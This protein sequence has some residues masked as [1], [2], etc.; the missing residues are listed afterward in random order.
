MTDVLPKEV[1]YFGKKENVWI[2]IPKYVPNLVATLRVIFRG[3]GANKTRGGE[4]ERNGG[5]TF[6]LLDWSGLC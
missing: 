3:S 1:E 6:Q 5:G 2:T 4:Q